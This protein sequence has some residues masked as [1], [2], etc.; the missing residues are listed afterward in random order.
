MRMN[1][2]IDIRPILGE[3]E[4]PTLVLHRADERWVA[5]GNSRFL[6]ERIPGAVLRELPGS[7]HWPWAGD[8]DGL[9]SAVE[10]FLDSV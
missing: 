5:V 2:E 9:L 8:F 1:A 6:A 10:R 4:V 3:L 7:D